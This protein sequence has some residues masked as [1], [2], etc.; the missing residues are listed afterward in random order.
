VAGI[1]CLLILGTPL[2]FAWG[3]QKGHQKSFMDQNLNLVPPEY[4]AG[5]LPPSSQDLI[6]IF[7]L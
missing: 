6:I 5:V 4:E 2:A 7:L 1:S 3:A